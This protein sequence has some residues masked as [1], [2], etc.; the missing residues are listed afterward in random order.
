[1]LSQGLTAEVTP[2][3]NR[4]QVD[5]KVL[6]NISMGFFMS[7]QTNAEYVKIKTFPIALFPHLQPIFVTNDKN[8]SSIF[9]LENL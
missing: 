3:L 7:D 8:L 5:E 1:M 9:V 2:P 4:A 6:K